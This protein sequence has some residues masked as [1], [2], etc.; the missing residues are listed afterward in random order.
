MQLHQVKYLRTYIGQL[1]PVVFKCHSLRV[2]WCTAVKELS[3]SVCH[4]KHIRYLNLSEG[5]FKTLAGGTFA[6][7]GPTP[8]LW[9][10]VKATFL[11]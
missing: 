10:K 8:P 5:N 6:C 1:Y 9:V 3:N 4:L 11:W 7:V 2:L